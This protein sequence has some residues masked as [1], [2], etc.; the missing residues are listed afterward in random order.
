MFTDKTYEYVSAV[1]DANTMNSYSTR[2]T[3][4]SASE[5]LSTPHVPNTDPIY[6][7]TDPEY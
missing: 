5:M 1:D 7:Y 4:N 6:N 2:L 3:R